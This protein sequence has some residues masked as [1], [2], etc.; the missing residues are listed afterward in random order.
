MESQTALI[1]RAFKYCKDCLIDRG[2]YEKSVYTEVFSDEAH[3]LGE[4]M[5]H[6][7]LDVIEDTVQEDVDIL[8]QSEDPE[9]NGGETALDQPTVQVDPGPAADPDGADLDDP[10]SEDP[11]VDDKNDIDFAEDKN[12][13]NVISG[14]GDNQEIVSFDYKKN[15]VACWRAHK[16][17]SLISLKKL[18]NMSKIP[19]KRALLK[20][21]TQVD[22]GKSRG[23]AS[24]MKLAEM[25]MDRFNIARQSLRP[26]H[27]TDLRYWAIQSARSLGI[28]NFK[29]SNSWLVNFR[30][31]NR[32]RQRRVARFI[33]SKELA[34]EDH[35]QAS[36]LL[37]KTQLAAQVP[38]FDA[39]YVI[40][41]DQTGCEFRIMRNKT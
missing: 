35:I 22:N 20:W 24:M 40:N 4:K 29:A 37:F 12:K 27:Y 33:S 30:R 18:K 25:T 6:A 11:D 23:K 10:D 31:G 39:K 2:W 36:A 14:G 15:A 8:F 28:D 32:I 41:T 21:A 16:K 34:S 7:L 13:I 17:Y 26:V 5:F 3:D 1:S 38:I 19:S 9:G